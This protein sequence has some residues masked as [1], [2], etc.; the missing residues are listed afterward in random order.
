[1]RDGHQSL[2]ATRMRNATILG[3]AERID[4]MGFQYV[5]LVGGA[6]FDVC[7]RYLRE[8][9][10]ERMRLVAQRIRETPVQVHTRGQS[11][12]TFQLFP[13]EVVALAVRRA[14]ANGMRHIFSYDCLNDIR[15][16]E[17]TVKT[18][19]EEDM[20]VTGGLVYTLSPVHTD[21]HYV[22]RARELVRLGVH[23]VCVK[24]PSGLLT[25]ERVRTLVPSLRAAIDD[26]RLEL[27]THARSGL[28][29][30]C[31]IEGVQL[32]ADDVHTAIS[33]L[34][35]G[36][37]HSPTEWV[38]HHLERKGFH[39]G[40]NQQALAEMAEY[41]T[42]VAERDGMPLGGRPAE[43]DPALYDHQIP[44]GQ[45]SN[46]INQLRELGI[47]HRLD[48][49]MDEMFRVRVDLGYPPVVSPTAQYVAT[50]AVLN[51]L[52]GERY[53]IV[54]LEVKNYVLGYYGRPPSPVDPALLDRVA[55]RDE[56][57]TGRA[58][59]RLEPVLAKTS[60]ERGPFESDDD[61]LHA[62]FYSDDICKAL[63][64]ARSA[65]AGRYEEP[66]GG[67][68][69]AHLLKELA[70]REGVRHFQLEMNGLRLRVAR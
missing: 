14:R 1:M 5:D 44:G 3:F 11:L 37:S 16:L 54:P 31:L 66:N 19:L 34:S 36:A 28:A 18:A 4:G 55:A 53:K 58:G 23:S 48:E 32:G 6:V 21:E 38:V 10:W 24:D 69:V 59:E 70:R 15:N 22:E 60:R 25:P 45:I 9:P 65:A 17:V 40:V 13:D 62:V 42:W 2:W 26:R 39:T 68:P 41:F 46:L 61:L 8:D 33:P 49:V 43:Y 64:E 56:P 27:H 51:V 30:I 20:S 12:F 63:F 67:T 50:Q 57:Y 47:E 29:P 52:H 35:H 7:V